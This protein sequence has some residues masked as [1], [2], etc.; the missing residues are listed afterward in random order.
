M[1]RKF[2]FSEFVFS[3]TVHFASNL[4]RTCSI[5]NE[6]HQNLWL[7]TWIFQ[8]EWNPFFKQVLIKMLFA[9]SKMEITMLK[10]KHEI[11]EES[12]RG[13]WILKTRK[14]LFL[15]TQRGPYFGQFLKDRIRVPNFH[16][17]S[18]KKFLQPII[19]SAL[20]FQSAPSFLWWNKVPNNIYLNHNSTEIHANGLFNETWKASKCMKI[21]KNS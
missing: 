8:L 19:W 16:L 11:C 14:T 3:R 18:K 12:Q 5:K 7:P 6:L 2:K 9:A 4:P 20:Q 15:K 21:H 17:N 13:T 1:W 10:I